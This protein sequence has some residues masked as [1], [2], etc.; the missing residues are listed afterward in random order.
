MAIAPG[1]FVEIEFIGKTTDND[2]FDTNIKEEAKKIGRKLQENKTIICIGEGMLLKS[3]DEFLIGKDLG[4]YTLSLT[5]EKAFGLRK[6]E[7]VKIM[8]SS[9]FKNSQYRPQAGMLFTFDNMI[10]KVNAV[11]GGRVVVDFNN[12]LAGKNVI[13]EL[14]IK[15][16]VTNQDEKVKSLMNYFFKR[17]FP[18][19]VKEEKIIIQAEKPY[20]EFIKIFEEPF[21]KLLN[22]GLEVSEA[23][24]TGKAEDNKE[25]E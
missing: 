5:P 15:S 8:P 16:K 1:E 24:N 21:K 6:K 19:E 10:G 11:S 23:K 2:I 3:I 22:L 4:K 18:F 9:V 14:D 20:I 25:K 13:Y 17:E 12:P 7:L